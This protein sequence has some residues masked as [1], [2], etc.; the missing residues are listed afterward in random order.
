MHVLL[1]LAN[2]PRH[3]KQLKAMCIIKDSECKS[4]FPI[5]SW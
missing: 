1:I 5:P 3:N 4:I 2:I